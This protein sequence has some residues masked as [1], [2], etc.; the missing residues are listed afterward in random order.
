MKIER[1]CNIDAPA[2]TTPMTIADAIVRECNDRDILEDVIYYLNCY[3]ERTYGKKQPSPFSGDFRIVDSSDNA[4]TIADNASLS[5]AAYIKRKLSE[6]S[7]ALKNTEM[8]EASEDSDDTE[9]EI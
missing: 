3:I 4:T 9:S 8:S 2:G 6:A 5:Y 7:E 1:T